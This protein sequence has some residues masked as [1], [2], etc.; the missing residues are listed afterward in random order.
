M[1]NCKMIRFQQRIGKI[2]TLRVDEWV[3]NVYVIAHRC[4]F[5]RHDYL[6]KQVIYDTTRED[7]DVIGKEKWVAADRIDFDGELT[8]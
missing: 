2:G 6:V 3:V 8:Q 1:R 4:V 5:G 7:Y